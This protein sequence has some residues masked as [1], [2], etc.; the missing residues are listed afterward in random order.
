MPLDVKKLRGTVTV[1]DGAWGTELDK[2]G[3]PAGYCREEWNV[4]HPDAVQSVAA[5]Y[6]AA[7]SQ[8]I[9]TNTLTGNRFMLDRHGFGDRAAEFNRA[10][11]A[12]SRTAAGKKANVFGSIGPSGK[13]VMM[14][15]ISEDELYDAFKTQAVALAE[16][17]ADGIVCE[18]M[19]ELAEALIALRAAKENTGLPV[20]VSL[21][22]DSGPDR[23]QTMMGVTPKQAADELT[24]AGA[25]IIGCNC[26][27]GIEDYIAV[28]KLLRKATDL[29]IWVKANA[30]MPE[31]ED[32]KVTYKDTP[33]AFAAKIPKL[34]A[35]GA[36][37]VGG[38]C[39]TSPDYIRAIC[40]VIKAR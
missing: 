8:V 15:E 36:N 26:G 39:G 21:T 4:S 24:A 32:G 28:A 6:V 1:C 27:V 2:R 18:T 30:G 29:P 31:L 3:V 5:A 10:G 37:V 19:T 33:E 20:A 17:G 11:A 7:G 34:I 22:Y 9:L 23:T 35:A 14:D 12:I 25:D 13:I 40:Q 16:G 38:C